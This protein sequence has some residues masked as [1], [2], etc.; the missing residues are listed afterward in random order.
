MYSKEYIAL[1]AQLIPT[2]LC[3]QS[4][5]AEIS[6]ITADKIQIRQELGYDS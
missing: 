4:S 5:Y 1:F 6:G 3:L 2:N